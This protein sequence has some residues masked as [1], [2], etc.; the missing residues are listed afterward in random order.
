MAF[1]FWQATIFT[2]D[3]LMRSS[4]RNFLI[5][6]PLDDEKF[7]FFYLFW[8]HFR[9]SALKGYFAKLQCKIWSQHRWTITNNDSEAQWDSAC[10]LR[11]KS[12][13]KIQSVY[14]NSID[15]ELS[16]NHFQWPLVPV[17]PLLDSL[18]GNI[19]LYF[20]ACNYPCGSLSTNCCLQ[21]SACNSLSR[22]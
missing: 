22:I 2:L 5:R 9:L 6:L 1:F 18:P 17:S 10:R 12:L 4:G 16:V 20:S 21:F 19:C 13:S 8:N 7:S 11:V 14:S 15:R 3:P